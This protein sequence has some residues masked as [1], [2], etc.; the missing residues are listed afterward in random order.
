MVTEKVVSVA[1]FILFFIVPMFL[2]FWWLLVRPVS[3][4]KQND[5]QE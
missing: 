4:E 3:N 5:T 1:V 2:L